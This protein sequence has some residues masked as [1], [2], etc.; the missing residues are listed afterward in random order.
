M[1]FL[2]A[3]KNATE[4]LSSSEYPSSCIMLLFKAELASVLDASIIDSDFIA[5]MRARFDHGFPINE[6]HVCAANA[7]HAR[8][9]SAS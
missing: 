6:L 7:R 2:V 4:L 3:F 8:P 9:V 1:N 5:D